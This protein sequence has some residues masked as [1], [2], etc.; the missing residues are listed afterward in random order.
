VRLEVR[1]LKRRLLILGVRWSRK[2]VFDFDVRNQTSENVQQVCS[3]TKPA[4]STQW[5]TTKSRAII[6]TIHNCRPPPTV[7]PLLVSNHDDKNP[8]HVLGLLLQ[9]KAAHLLLSL[10]QMRPFQLASSR[11]QFIK[12]RCFESQQYFVA[13]GRD[14]P[15]LSGHVSSTGCAKTT[16]KAAADWINVG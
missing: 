14:F 2:N 9:N 4:P 11:V 15:G 8:A 7:I 16:E 5:R 6:Y 1:L 10:S 3:C 13:F 12:R